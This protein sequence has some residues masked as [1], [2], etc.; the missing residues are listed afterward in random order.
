MKKL[1]F[2]YFVL[3]TAF[4]YSEPIYTENIQEEQDLYSFPQL[5]EKTVNSTVWISTFYDSKLDAEYGSIKRFFFGDILKEFLGSGFIYSKEGH[6]LTNYH[7]IKDCNYFEIQFADDTICQAQVI[8]C[9]E[10]ADIAVL[11]VNKDN[12]IPLIL[13][14]EECKIGQWIYAIGNPEFLRNS[15]TVGVIAGKNRFENY[16]YEDYI[17]LDLHLNQGN[18]GGPILNLNGKIIGMAASTMKGT[19]ISF[20]IPSN[21]LKNVADQLIKK[22]IQ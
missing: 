13:E 16:P 1:L 3:S 20:I 11:K 15:F 22:W 7:V 18:S 4:L 21:I 17:Q 9:D 12:L 14:D 5:Y 2:F 8:G 10:N 19:G 6:I